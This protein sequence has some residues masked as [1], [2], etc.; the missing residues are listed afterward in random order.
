MSNIIKFPRNEPG[1]P[2]TASH[3]KRKAFLAAVAAA[4]L[5]NTDFSR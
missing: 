5:G 2:V 1:E 3:A 4:W